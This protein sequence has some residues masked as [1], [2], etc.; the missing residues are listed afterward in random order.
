MAC[1]R[2]CD[3]FVVFCI[4]AS[5]GDVNGQGCSSSSSGGGFLAEVI[6]RIAGTCKSCEQVFCLIFF[7]RFLYILQVSLWQHVI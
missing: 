2:W 1:I 4:V 7:V 6:S 3:C 5:S